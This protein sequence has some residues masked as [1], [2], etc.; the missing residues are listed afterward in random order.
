MRTTKQV[1]VDHRQPV[2]THLLRQAVVC[3]GGVVGAYAGD[4]PQLVVTVVND[5]D[6]PQ[7]RARFVDVAAGALGVAASVGVEVTVVA[8][9]GVPFVAR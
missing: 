1:V 8:D 2:N 9:D 6:L 3:A 7:T 5:E 4:A